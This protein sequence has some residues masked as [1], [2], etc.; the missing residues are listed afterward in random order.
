MLQGVLTI[1]IQYHNLLCGIRATCMLIWTNLRAVLKTRTI[2]SWLF[3][4]CAVNW[5]KTKQTDFA[6]VYLCFPLNTQCHISLSFLR[7]S[8][9]VSNF[10]LNRMRF[11]IQIFKWP[12]SAA[13][14]TQA[15]SAKDSFKNVS[16][17]LLYC[18]TG[19]HYCFHAEWFYMQ[20][21]AG[22]P[23]HYLYPHHRHNDESVNDTLI[24]RF[25]FLLPTRFLDKL[26]FGLQCWAQKFL[27]YD[28]KCML[29]LRSYNHRCMFMQITFHVC[30]TS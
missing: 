14:F 17:V 2:H 25:L 4:V 24:A 3:C 30:Y 6:G 20:V 1:I 21:T 29:F 10:T 13:K 5:H 23:A 16:T 27:E 12:I 11:V 28:H 8:F 9:A 22:M 19:F 26:N 15:S 7:L 18:W